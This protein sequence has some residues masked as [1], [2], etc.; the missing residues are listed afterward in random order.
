MRWVA[1]VREQCACLA[2]G[3]PHGSPSAMVSS[4]FTSPW[5]STSACR[6][7]KLEDCHAIDPSQLG[8]SKITG[9]GPCYC[10]VWPKNKKRRYRE[11]QKKVVGKEVPISVR[12][13]PL[14]KGNYFSSCLK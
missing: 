6:N 13:V 10:A 8:A 12:D 14:L 3:S 4:L 2:G 5:H 1:E 9:I 11:W 7:T